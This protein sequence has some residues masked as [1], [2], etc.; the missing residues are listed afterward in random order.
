MHRM[1]QAEGQVL[2]SFPQDALSQRIALR[3]R[4][5]Q[6]LRLAAR[7]AADQAGQF[8]GRLIG[9]AFPDFSVNRP[10]GTTGF[11]SGAS[12]IQA[13]VP[14][15]RL[16]G[17]G[18]VIDMAVHDQA[19]T[20]AAAQGDVKHRIAAAARPTPRFTQRAHVGVVVGQDRRL[21]PLLQP[22]GQRKSRQAFNLMGTLNY[23]GAPIDGAAKP[24]AD[25]LWP[26]EG[27][28]PGPQGVV[29]LLPD[30]GAAARG[31]Y[32]GA[33]SI[34]NAR[35][36]VSRHQLQFRAADFDAPKPGVGGGRGRSCW[37][38]ALGFK[39]S[40]ARRQNLMWR[41]LSRGEN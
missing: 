28:S 25:R 6:M 7:L 37:L 4:R 20:H 18:A 29:D 14:N 15:L 9:A 23:A 27:W 11:H 24:D 5:R 26:G 19:A 40:A 21:D 36:R 39:P 22:F 34:A 1:R 33:E 12:A 13:N 31:I 2:G 30:A 17:K 16:A 8:A 3:Q 35:P 38:H 10:A 41:D 32:R